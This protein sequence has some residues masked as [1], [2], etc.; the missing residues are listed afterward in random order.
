MSSPSSTSFTAYDHLYVYAGT[1]GRER[2]ILQNVVD[3]HHA[4]TATEQTKPIV[5]IMALVGLYLHVERAFSGLQVQHVHMQ[6]GRKKH[7][8]PKLVLPRDRGSITAEDVMEAPEGDARDAAIAEWCRSVWESYAE[9]R[10]T[11]VDLLQ[12]HGVIA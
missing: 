8:W 11:I 2:F 9:N 6:L 10:P 7:Q 1:R 4:Q 3:A 5:M 12:R